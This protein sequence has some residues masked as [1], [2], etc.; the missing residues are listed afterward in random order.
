[1]WHSKRKTLAKIDVCV[2]NR[3]QI[4][5][6]T[7][8]SE[9]ERNLGQNNKTEPNTCDGNYYVSR[10][11]C[12]ILTSVWL[13][14]AVQIEKSRMRKPHKVDGENL[15][16]M[17][18]KNTM[19]IPGY[20][21]TNVSSRIFKLGAGMFWNVVSVARLGTRSGESQ[22]VAISGQRFVLTRC[23]VFFPLNLVS[24]IVSFSLSASLYK[25]NRCFAFARCIQYVKSTICVV[26]SNIL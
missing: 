14:T 16:I 5:F 24:F 7:H 8:L 6:S 9:W 23:Q 20:L 11:G 1:M 22:R 3:M 13:C 25:D 21:K 18:D 10:G 26:V 12:K 4:R 19:C 17:L 15:L 2:L